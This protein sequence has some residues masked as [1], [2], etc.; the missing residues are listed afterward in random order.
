MWIVQFHIFLQPFIR[1][2]MLYKKEEKGRKKEKKEKRRKQKKG[3]NRKKESK[4]RREREIDGYKQ[5][6]AE[7]EGER[8]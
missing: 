7:R 5:N 8:G 4:R 2:V 1:S 6:R 3:E